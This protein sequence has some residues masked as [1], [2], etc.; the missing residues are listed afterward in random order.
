MEH[1][2]NNNTSWGEDEP[3]EGLISL[4]LQYLRMNIQDI[5]FFMID[6]LYAF[7]QNENGADGDFSLLP[8]I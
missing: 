1:L 3:V 2:P 6:L 8:P 7:T 4:L 5:I